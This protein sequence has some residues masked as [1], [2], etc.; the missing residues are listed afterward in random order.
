MGGANAQV[1]PPID[2]DDM[3]KPTATLLACMLGFTSL[4]ALSGEQ[5]ASK[6]DAEQMVKKAVAYYRKNGRE[7]AFAAFQRPGPFIDRDLYVSVYTLD[8]VSVA[9]INQ[10]MIGKNMMDLR[11]PSGKYFVRERMEAARQRDS[12]WQDYSFFNPV[13]K[14]IEP[15]DMY[16]Q[17]ADDL[18]FAVGA[19]RT[20]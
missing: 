3:T 8:G 4:T 20:Q 7:R 12:G 10:R 19:Y 15:K 9:H 13:T 6:A 14:K 16:W 18:V 17:R 1:T 5:H 2:H 11:D